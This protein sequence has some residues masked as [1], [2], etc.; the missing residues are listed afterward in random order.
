M[1]SSN[2][3]LARRAGLKTTISRPTASARQAQKMAMLTLQSRRVVRSRTAI[4]SRARGARKRLAEAT[5]CAARG[6]NT[7]VG[8][9]RMCACVWVSVSVSVYTRVVFLISTS[10]LQRSHPYF[11]MI[12]GRS[13]SQS[14]YQKGGKQ[15]WA[16]A[17]LCV[18]RLAVRVNGSH[19]VNHAARRLHEG[20]V[21]FQLLSRSAR[22]NTSVSAKKRRGGLIPKR[23]VQNHVRQRATTACRVSSCWCPHATC[24]WAI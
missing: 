8:G 21:E 10:E 16:H 7:V 9:W 5:R 3:R 18:P 23:T 17:S 4:G 1:R 2:L 24:R 14:P 19:P 13:V 20:L 6:T 11:S 22:A 15:H 12:I